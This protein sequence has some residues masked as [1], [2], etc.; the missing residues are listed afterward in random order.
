MKALCYASLTWDFLRSNLSNSQKIY[1][2]NFALTYRCNLQC[3]TCNIWKQRYGEELSLSEIDRFFS[4]YSGF[5]WISLTGGE[6]F[7][8]QDL[9]GILCS[10]CR[11]NPGLALL[12]LNTNGYLSEYIQEVILD[13]SKASYRPPRVI[14]TVSMDGPPDLHDAMRGMPGSWD[15]AI[16]SFQY[17]KRIPG[18]EVIFGT[19]LSSYNMD[20]LP[21]MFE[22]LKQALPEFRRSDLHFNLYNVSEHYYGNQDLD[23]PNPGDLLQALQS[24]LASKG[25]IRAP[26]SLLDHV[27]LRLTEQYLRTGKTPIPCEACKSSCFIDPNGDI[28][29]CTMYT[30]K[31]GNLRHTDHQ[32]LPI[33]LG[34]EAKATRE[35]IQRLDCPNCWTPCESYQSI[36]GGIRHVIPRLLAKSK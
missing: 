16:Q 10:A 26:L 3:K 8:R 19:T 14:V 28:Y 18:I 9:G 5:H 30:R 17:L 24:G 27:F 7:L 11:R 12:A 22:A 32:F 1:K 15:R 20:H 6:T 34:K 25:E 4:S 29:P 33:M 13:L 21:A 31:L 36:F 23:P 35:V 2:I